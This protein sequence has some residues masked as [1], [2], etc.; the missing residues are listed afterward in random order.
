V[1]VGDAVVGDGDADEEP[2]AEAVGVVLVVATGTLWHWEAIAVDVGAAPAVAPCRA[3]KM[4]RAPMLKQTTS[5]V[6]CKMRIGSPPASG[7]LL[8]CQ[9]AGL[10]NCWAVKTGQAYSWAYS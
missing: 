3:P 6:R 8:C 5:V 10:S 7:L 1:G 2:E 4:T 9:T